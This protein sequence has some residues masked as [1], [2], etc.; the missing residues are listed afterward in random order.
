MM[1]ADHPHWSFSTSNW[2]VNSGST[3]SL[4][5]QQRRIYKQNDSLFSNRQSTDDYETSSIEGSVERRRRR[6]HKLEVGLE[7]GRNEFRKR[8]RGSLNERRTKR[9]DSITPTKRGMSSVRVLK[10]EQTMKKPRHQLF[11]DLDP[12]PHPVTVDE[13]L[14]GNDTVNERTAQRSKQSLN[15][16]QNKHRPLKPNCMQKAW[17]TRRRSFGEDFMVVARVAQELFE[18]ELDMDGCQIVSDKKKSYRPLDSMFNHPYTGMIPVCNFGEFVRDGIG[19]EPLR[20][21]ANLEYLLGWMF[22]LIVSV[23]FIILVLIFVGTSVGMA[24]SRPTVIFGDQLIVT[25]IPIDTKYEPTL[26]PNDYIDLINTE[27]D[28]SNCL[29]LQY[30]SIDIP[31][32][33]TLT[34]PLTISGMQISIF[35]YIPGVTTAKEPPTVDYDVSTGL[36]SEILEN[37]LLCRWVEW[38]MKE[39]RL[40]EP[41][42]PSRIFLMSK[43]A[44]RSTGRL[45]GGLNTLTLIVPMCISTEADLSRF[46]STCETEKQVQFIFK[47]H[48]FYGCAWVIQLPLAGWVSESS[49]MNCTNT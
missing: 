20:S 5:I 37:K 49:L 15:S 27:N 9:R 45:L 36:K 35:Q 29:L 32:V 23:F 22:I 41:P 21:R 12:D 44:P 38:T 24:I 11:D 34:L 2:R 31:Y 13:K 42:A 19:D 39:P 30:L 4:R 43:M 10:S 46:K 48:N 1:S 16:S 26:L 8:R 28:L 14:G 7:L 25:A 17:I 33:S 40:R 6:K 18:R 3:E 47:L